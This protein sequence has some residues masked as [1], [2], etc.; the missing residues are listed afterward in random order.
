MNHVA[1]GAAKPQLNRSISR[2]GAKNAKG[3]KLRVLRAFVVK[4]LFLLCGE[5]S[6]STL[7]AALPRQ[8]LRGE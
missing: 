4:C 8:A 3:K 6:V 1:L 7:V 5:I 2:K